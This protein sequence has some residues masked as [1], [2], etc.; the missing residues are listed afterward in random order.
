MKDN[1][2]A[3][4]PY[5]QTIEVKSLARAYVAFQK[6][7]SIYDGE[8]AIVKGTLFPELDMPY[9]EKDKNFMREENPCFEK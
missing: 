1:E 9:C 8:K 7:C 5:E 4:V 6:F 3:C 2:K